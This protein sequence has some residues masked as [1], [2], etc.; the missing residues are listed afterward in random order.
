VRVAG[1][2]PRPRA[3]VAE[4]R[5]QPS[6]AQRLAAR[7]SLRDQEQRAALAVGPL[8]EDVALHQPANLTVDGDTA[9]L[10]ALAKHAHPSQRDID[11]ID[12]EPADLGAAQPREQHQPRDR[13]VTHT[14]KARE[15][16]GDLIASQ[17]AWQPPRRAH[18]QPRPRHRR[19][20]MP[21]QATALTA[22]SAPG[23]AP[24]RDRVAGPWIAHLAKRE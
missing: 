13:T 17:P 10:L 20:Q 22:R 14:A 11:V 19:R 16:L 1:G 3:V 5:A 7:R 6:R 23:L 21:E 12:R 2:H 9:L 15:Q 8:A 18:P 24:S 4:H